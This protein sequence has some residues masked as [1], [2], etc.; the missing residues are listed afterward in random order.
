MS[1]RKDAKKI[2]P[3][4]AWF[5]FRNI[6]HICSCQVETNW[7][8]KDRFLSDL[9]G[10]TR[11][12]R[13]KLCKHFLHQDSEQIKLY[14]WMIQHQ[15]LFWTLKSLGPF[16]LCLEYDILNLTYFDM[17]SFCS[18]FSNSFNNCLLSIS[19]CLVFCL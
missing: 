7:L 17:L 15:Q 5:L 18:S 4:V 9:V 16:C 1:K 6:L 11:F 14:L 2:L 12:K 13:Q 3:F 8:R 19:L 10:N